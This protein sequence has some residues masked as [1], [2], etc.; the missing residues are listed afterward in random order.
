[1]TNNPSAIFMVGI[2]LFCSLSGCIEDSSDELESDIL[3]LENQNEQLNNT[4]TTLRMEN[5]NLL[6]QIVS[7]NNSNNNSAL[8]IQLLQLENQILEQNLRLQS[9]EHNSSLAL[10]N[11]EIENLQNLLDEAN[12]IIFE[13]LSAEAGLMGDPANPLLFEQYDTNGTYMNHA[14]WNGGLWDRVIFDDAGIPLVQYHDGLKYV[15]TT[16][17]HWGLVSFSK[18]ITTGNQSNFD[19]AMEVAI[20]AVEN[21][22]EVGGW[23]WFFNHSFHG[24]YLGF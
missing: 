6:S 5:E 23:G 3:E 8:Q 7:L 1:M 14:N 9:L 20:W 4:I 16:A 17:F 19:D 13:Y 15:P 24:V 22:S 2:I 18:W 21:Q 10:L 12:Q 11:D